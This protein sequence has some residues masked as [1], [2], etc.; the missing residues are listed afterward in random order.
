MLSPPCYATCH[1]ASAFAD[2]A[3]CRQPLPPRLRQLYAMMPIAAADIFE[4]FAAAA[5]AAMSGRRCR[6][7]RVASRNNTIVITYAFD[8][9]A[10]AP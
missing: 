8:V 2:A 5:I 6:R 9:A 10:A 3:A 4:F 7:N 1:A